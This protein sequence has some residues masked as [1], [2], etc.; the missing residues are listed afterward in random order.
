MTKLLV[1]LNSM[2]V[3][4]ALLLASAGL[5][6]AGPKQGSAHHNQTHAVTPHSSQGHGNSDFGH[7]QGDSA[8]RT[9]GHQNNA[10]GQ[11]HK[12][13]HATTSP[14]PGATAKPSPTLNPSPKPED[15]DND[16]ETNDGDGD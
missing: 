6:I 7:R 1:K 5:V 11:Q 8:T 4:G 3:V 12:D 15:N 14:T 13:G 2:H 9:R 10:F 16:E